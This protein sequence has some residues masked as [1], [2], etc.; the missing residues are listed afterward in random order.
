[1]PNTTPPNPSTPPVE[2]VKP[3]VTLTRPEALRILLKYLKNPNLIKHSFAAEAAM[4]ALYD[5][6][7]LPGQRND[8]DREK[9]GITG[10]LHDADYDMCKNHPEKHG[11][12]LF[13]KEPIAIPDDIM[14]AIK[15]H[16]YKYTKVMP[17]SPMDWAITTC[18]QLTGLIVAATLVSP[19]KRIAAV[20]P[21]FVYNRYKQS[22]FAQGADRK[23]IA[24]CEPQLGIP[25]MQFI[26]VVLNG[27]KE[28]NK[29]LGL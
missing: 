12:L 26:E 9:W 15:S 11:L 28:I 1:M 17:K 14:Y 8:Q 6:L 18:D 3:Q 7:T 5:R 4:K 23:T 27:M 2:E 16:N 25:L 13:E 24:L 19:E 20:Y 10:L 22:S 21:E 29:E